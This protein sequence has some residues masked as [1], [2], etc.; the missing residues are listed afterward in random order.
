MSFPVRK[1]KMKPLPAAPAPARDVTLNREAFAVATAAL[2]DRNTNVLVTGR[3]GTGK[4]T[5]IHDVL[6]EPDIKQVVV[7]PTG[8]AA[9]QA[10]GQTVHSFFQLAPRLQNFSEIQPVKG[11]KRKLIKSLQRLII[12]EISMVRADLLDKIDYALK[13]NRGSGAPFGGVQVLMV[14]DFFQLPPVVPRHEAE[15]LSAAG[16]ESFH[17][18]GAKCLR[19]APMKAVELQ[20]VFRQS[21]PEFIE[22]LGNIRGGN[23]VV[24]TVERINDVCVGNHRAGRIPLLLTGTNNGADAYNQRGLAALAGTART[25]QSSTSG[26][27]NLTGDNLPA[28]EMLELKVGARVMMVKNDTDKRWVNG[29]LATVTRCGHADISVKLDNDKTYD[30]DATKWERF[31]SAYNEATG[32]IENAVV[33]TYTQLPVKLAWASTVHKAQ[34]L[35]LDDVRVDLNG[36]AFATGQAYVALSRATSMAGLSLAQ[37]LQ[38]RDVSV[39]RDVEALL[40]R[41]S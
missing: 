24:R 8:V 38:S 40:L 23:D 19:H 39:D 1:P 36:G 25:Y 30:V 12:D 11:N 16:Y 22:L 2:A 21:D 37:P 29:T 6:A 14:G 28:P 10:R 34:G 20:Q 3:A 18:L 13:I 27:F 5:F 41:Y 33:G 35:S 15:V 4:T 9:L 26:E 32:H 7:A 17:A 31:N